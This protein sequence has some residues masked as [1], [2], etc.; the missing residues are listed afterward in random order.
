VSGNERKDVV[1]AFVQGEV[2]RILGIPKPEGI[3]VDQGLFDMG[4]DSLMA[5]DLKSRLEAGVGQPLPST[6]TFNYPSVGALANFLLQDVLGDAAEPVPAPEREALPAEEEVA[7]RDSRA[8]MSE[9]DLAALL[10][11]KLD[12]L[13]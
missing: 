1:L 10:R 2:A 7:T 12:Q 4:L 11:R 13:S 8:D 9:E 6:L 3:D 5:V